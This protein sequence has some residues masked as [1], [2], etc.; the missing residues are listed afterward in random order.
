MNEQMVEVKCRDRWQAYR[1]LKELDIACECRAYQ[2]LKVAV[3]GP[4]Q[5]LQAW[6][7]LQAVSGDRQQLIPR[8]LR[9]WQL[10][11]KQHRS[12]CR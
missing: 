5:M 6:S 2:P 3:D 12:F 11:Q 4:S 1:R 9:C 10:P 8:L 7:A